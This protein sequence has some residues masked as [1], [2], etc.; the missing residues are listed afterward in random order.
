MAA[1]NTLPGGLETTD[2]LSK[3]TGY[4]PSHLRRLL[5]Q[6]KIK[7]I[8]V[9]TGNRAIWF[10]TLQEVVEYRERITGSGNSFP[11]GNG[12]NHSNHRNYMT[13][14]KPLRKR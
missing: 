10:T 11:A 6:Q 8:K 14:D 12:S 2:T 7:G 5:I 4:D 9:G 13:A 3:K 1:K